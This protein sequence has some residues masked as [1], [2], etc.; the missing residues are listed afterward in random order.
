MR[1]Q[2]G[3]KYECLVAEYAKVEVCG[4]IR[5]F[6]VEGFDQSEI[7]RR[8]QGVYGLNGLCRKQVNV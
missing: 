5:I 4:V 2:E 6:K 8:T 3:K 7:D 1:F